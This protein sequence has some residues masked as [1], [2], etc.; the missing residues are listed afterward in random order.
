[1]EWNITAHD[2]RGYVEVITSGVAD[3]EGSLKM[4][5]ALA[6]T[7]QAHRCKKALIDHRKVEFIIGDTKSFNNRPQAFREADPNMGIMI[8]EIIRREHVGH[9]EYLKTI[10]VQLGHTVSVFQDRDK[11][12]TWL[13][14]E[15]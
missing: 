13:L 4:A 10:F 7:M 2:E 15:T 3:G 12:L 8:A 11:A 5:A 1:M 14:T 9:F 6:E